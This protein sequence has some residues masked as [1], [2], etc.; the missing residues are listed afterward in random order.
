MVYNVAAKL[1]PMNG[2]PNVRSWF[3]NTMKNG[4]TSPTAR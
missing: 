1:E 3:E 4:Q 2:D